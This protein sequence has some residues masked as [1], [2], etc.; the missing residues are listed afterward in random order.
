MPRLILGPERRT[1]LWVWCAAIICMIIAIAVIITGVVVFAG[2]MIMKPRIPSMS[3]NY[4]FLDKLNYD[5]SG[6]VTLQISLI[7]KAENE[8]MKA[9]ASFSDVNFILNFHGLK[10]AELRADP[11]VLPKNDSVNLA[12]A[13][14]SMSIPFEQDAWEDMVASVKQDKVSFSLKGDARTRWRVGIIGPVKFWTHLSCQLNFFASNGSSIKTHC[15]SKS[16]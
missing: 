6:Q 13:V 5:Q 7:I 2:Y 3:V 14:P 4:A 8:N 16:R 11:F 15:S 10:I 12:Y 1:R 9:D